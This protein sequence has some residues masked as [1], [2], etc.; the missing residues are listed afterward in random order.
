MSHVTF[1]YFHSQ[2]GPR[3]RPPRVTPCPLGSCT[4]A[5]AAAAGGVPTSPPRATAAIALSPA[6]AFTPAATE[7]ASLP[8]RAARRPS[9]ARATGRRRRRRRAAALERLVRLRQ[10]GEDSL[11]LQPHR[12]LSGHDLVWVHSTQHAEVALLD[13]FGGGSRGSRRHNRVWHGVVASVLQTHGASQQLQQR[14][15]Y[16]TQN[17]R[18]KST[19]RLQKQR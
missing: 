13:V 14:C 2:S 17:A 9:S 5:A 10:H 12:Q 4:D 1:T 19:T 3:R 11:R 6:G 16:T 7:A 15:I 8:V 18:C